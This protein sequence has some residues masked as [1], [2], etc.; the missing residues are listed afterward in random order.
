MRKALYI[1]WLLTFLAVLSGPAIA[2]D[3]FVIATYSMT[4]PHGSAIIN[5]GWGHVLPMDDFL[6]AKRIETYAIYDPDLKKLDFPFDSSANNDI[7]HEN[8]GRESK[9]FPAATLKTGDCFVQKVIFKK[10]A[11]DGVYQ[12]ASSL[13][14][15]SNCMG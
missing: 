14:N 12:V 4:H 11:P 5:L 2:H 1:F 8:K 6:P 9:N 15:L 13:K 3:F 10:T 7:T